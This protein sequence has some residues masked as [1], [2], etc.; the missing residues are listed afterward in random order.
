MHN[1]QYNE[2]EAVIQD[3]DEKLDTII[4][5]LYLLHTR[6]YATGR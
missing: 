2:M 5:K 1:V 4:S 3:L 6:S